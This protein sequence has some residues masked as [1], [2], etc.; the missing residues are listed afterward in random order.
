MTS[1]RF[2]EGVLD[3]VEGEKAGRLIRRNI[4]PGSV[5]LVET[6]ANDGRLWLKLKFCAFMMHDDDIC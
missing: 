1:M 5:M 6:G 2:W 4:F 3:C